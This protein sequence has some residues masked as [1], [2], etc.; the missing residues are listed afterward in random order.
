MYFVEGNHDFGF[1]HFKSTQLQA[2]FH[3]YGDL[4]IE[5]SHPHLGLVHLRHGD[6]VVCH[7]GYLAF[8][9]F[10]KNKWFQK[11]A[12]ILFPGKFMQFIFSRYAKLSRKTDAYRTLSDEF[13]F[14]CLNSVLSQF[15]LIKVLIIGHIHIFKQETINNQVQFFSGPDWL[16]KPSILIYKENSFQRLF[17]TDESLERRRC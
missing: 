4:C 1:E 5:M 16:S 10:V 17:L 13:L 14:S 11:I 9:R 15:P 3:S 6:D 12:S 2:C 7:Q 8:R